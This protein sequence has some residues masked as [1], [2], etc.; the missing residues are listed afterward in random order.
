MEKLTHI[1]V[2]TDA[3]TALIMKAHG[4][5]MVLSM[6]HKSIADGLLVARAI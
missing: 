3:G 1:E 2:R 6:F 5:L 4:N